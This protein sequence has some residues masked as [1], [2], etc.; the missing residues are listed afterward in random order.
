MHG[1]ETAPRTRIRIVRINYRHLRNNKRCAEKTHRDDHGCLKG[2]QKI[3]RV[4][5]I[6]LF[7]RDHAF[8][9]PP[10]LS[11]FVLGQP[12]EDSGGS[13]VGCR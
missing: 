9:V 1:K 2:K 6:R 5:Q 7:V 12:L 13:H 4:L 11:S 3:P 10:I 8:Q